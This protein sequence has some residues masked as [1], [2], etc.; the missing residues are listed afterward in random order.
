MGE[1][2]GGATPAEAI[3]RAAL[4]LAEQAAARRAGGG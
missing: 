4:A 3:V 1:L 2:S